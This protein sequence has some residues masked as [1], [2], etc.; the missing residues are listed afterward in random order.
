MSETPTNSTD[1]VDEEKEESTESPPAESPPASKSRRMAERTWWLPWLL[2]I[3]AVF[4]AVLVFTDTFDG[5]PAP[6]EKIQ[7]RQ[8]VLPTSTHTVLY[9]VTGTGKSPEIRYVVDGTGATDKVEGV[10]LPWRKEI[11]M[12]VGPG[13]GIAQLLA[14]N[15]E[16]PQVACTVS[17][18]GQPVNQGVAPGAF[19]NVA[20]SAVI[21]P[22][23]K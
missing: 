6:E 4:V 10:D 15:G 8:S 20:C 23:P 19:S 12:T 5:E 7:E 22:N 13:V 21:R 2:G 17:V 11:Q 3:A 9:E 16:S 14:A 18:D 1:V